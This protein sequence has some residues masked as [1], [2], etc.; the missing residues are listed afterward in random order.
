MDEEERLV[1]RLRE[2]KSRLAEQEERMPAHS[3]RVN[4]M[5]ELLR[6][7]E[8]RDRAEEELAVFRA[9]KSG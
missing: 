1:Q 8:E 4:Q 5:E 6:L 7:E 2:I 3:V 9:R